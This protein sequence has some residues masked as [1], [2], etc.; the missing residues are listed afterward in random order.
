MVQIFADSNRARM[1]YARESDSTWGTVPASGVTR[2]L[3]FTSSSINATKDT[4]TSDEVR[5]DR[6]ISDII[7]VGVK[8]GGDVNVEF[9]AGS[10]D[11]FL[12]CFSYGFW[13]RPMTLDSWSGVALAWATNA[14]L[15]YTGPDIT[16]YLTT[17]RRIRTVGFQNAANNDYF[18]ISGAAFS[19]GVTTITVTTTTSIVEAGTA[20][21]KVY[22]ANDVIVL[23]NTAIRCGTS[24]ASTFDSNTTNAFS[25]AVA[26]GQLVVGQQV[27][28]DG[29][30]YERGNVVVA[31][32]SVA[33]GATLAIFD[34]TKTITLQF[35]GVVPATSISV[36]L[37]GSVTLTGANIAAAVQAQYVL[38]NINVVAQAA[39]GTVSF[40][41]NSESGGSLVKAGDTGTSFT[42]TNFTGGNTTANGLFTLTSVANDTLGVSPA[43]PT[44]NNSTIRV[45]VKGSMLRNPGVVANVIPHSLA[46][47]TGFEDVTQYFLTTGQRVSGF[48]YDIASSAVIKGQFTLTGKGMARSATTVLGSGSYTPLGTTVTGVENATTNVGAITLNGAAL[49]TAVQSISVKGTNNHRQQM[50]VSNKFPVGVGAGRMEISGNAVVYFANGSLWDAFINHSTVALQ[51]SHSDVDSNAYYWTIPAANF[52]TDTVTP[53]GKDQDVMENISFMAKRDP[54]TACE[55]QI[56]RLSNTLPVG[57]F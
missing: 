48:S 22:D 8:A 10:H 11:D 1:R 39:T 12:E 30:G 7:Q 47:E 6:M 21:S 37:G 9:S 42:V 56:D 4:T 16:G 26:A 2:E 19:G 28:I 51:W 36:A 13:T 17:G 46:I 18:Q 41:N 52:D 40:K 43:P 20:Y 45:V 33:A 32:N 50:A 31:N 44:I 49:S 34:G 5:A 38:G 27:Y 53:G 55:F 54:N 23:N 3:R 14:T 29:L 15:T 57:A 35:G 25:A 24:G